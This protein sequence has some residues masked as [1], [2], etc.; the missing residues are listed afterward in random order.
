VTGEAREVRLVLDA[1]AIAAY[2]RGSVA[3][4]EI[5]I[6]VDAEH[7]AVII[8]LSCLIEA[9]HATALLQRDHLQMLIDHPA[10]F[11]VADDPDEWVALTELRTLVDRADRAS[12]A[13]VSLEYQ[14]DVMTRDARWYAS[15]AR[16]RRVLEF[17]D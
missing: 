3:V 7:G 6:E 4:G 5:L 16:G 2:A 12:A 8:P 9:A 17:D 11:L 10:T 14:V 1:T 13:L 15:V